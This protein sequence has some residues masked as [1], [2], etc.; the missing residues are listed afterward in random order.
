MTID[1]HPVDRTIRE[2]RTS[3][4]VDRDAPVPDDLVDLLIEAATWAPN[5]KRTWPWR[6]TVLSGDARGRL[7]RAMAEAGTELGLDP[8]KV[9][10]LPTKYERSAVVLLV[11]VR[12]DGDDVRRREDRDATA[13]AVQNLLLTA[14]AHGL[15]NYW[16]TVP[17][18]LVPSVRAVAGIDD[19]HDLVALV[20]LGWP[21]GS[22]AVPER[23]APAVTRLR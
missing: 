3:L 2:R 16:A 19:G 15:G 6:F 17:D 20:Y 21:T 4:L 14:T 18:G 22:V 7:G 1:E 8:A 11:W 13:A 5:H 10:K 23:P 9:E 12:L